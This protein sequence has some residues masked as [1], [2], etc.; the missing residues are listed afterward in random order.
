[1]QA[2]DVAGCLDDRS[3]APSRREVVP[4]DEPRTALLG[5][6]PPHETGRLI[7]LSFSTLLALGT[8]GSYRRS[9][10]GLSLGG[11]VRALCGVLHPRAIG[12]NGTMRNIQDVMAA[13]SLAQAE[14][15]YALSVNGLSRKVR[16]TA[17]TP[18]LFVLREQ[19]HLSG[20]RFGCGLAQCG[21]CTVHLEGKPIRSCVTPVAS[22]VGKKI[23]TLEGLAVAF[24][25]TNPKAAALGEG[26]KMHPVQ[27][28]WIEAQ[29]PQCGYCQNGW[30][31]YSAA[32]LGA[33]PAATQVEIKRYLSKL[34]CR[35]ATH[36]QILEAVTLAQKKMA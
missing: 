32:L 26:V 20:P 5:S 2:D 27:E 10:I 1:V 21:T 6:D 35:C 7:G 4:H 22:A 11:G 24:T 8:S 23:V 25:K 36:S 28:A 18:L 9:R 30:I 17:D 34:K 33:K 31:M 16:A 15:S 19:L 3:H 13:R 29:V 12:G 14:K